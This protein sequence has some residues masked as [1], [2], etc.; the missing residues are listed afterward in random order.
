MRAPA[1][2]AIVPHLALPLLLI[3]PAA[4]TTRGGEAFFLTGIYGFVMIF[5]AA[6]LAWLLRRRAL[7]RA[8]P[9]RMAI[10]PLLAL[11]ISFAAI[12]WFNYQLAPVR[13]YAHAIAT[14]VQADCNRLGGCPAAM[15]GWARRHDMYSSITVRGD[16][17]K[18][19]LLYR[20]DGKE[21]TV[22][23]YLLMESRIDCTGGVGRTL[24]C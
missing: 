13:A 12:A 7:G 19:P 1:G 14:Q 15:T 22:T 24:A 9:F 17:I 10:G 11:A 16:R 18:W 21:F 8:T 4:S 6:R 23:L 3:W 2:L 20:S 5:C